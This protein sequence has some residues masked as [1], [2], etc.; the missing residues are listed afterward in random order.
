M[1]KGCRFARTQNFPGGAIH[2]DGTNFRNCLSR[3]KTLTLSKSKNSSVIA[4]YLLAHTQKAAHLTISE[5]ARETGASVATISRFCNRLGYRNYR[6]FNLALAFS[7]VNH[8]SPISDIFQ[9]GDKPGVIVKKV[10]AINRQSLSDTESIFKMSELTSVAKLFK[11][12]GKAFLFGTGGSGLIAK[13]GALRFMALGITTS[14]ISDS[15]EGLLALSSGTKD[16]VAIGISHAG[17]SIG[18]LNM[19]RL[20]RTKGLKTVGIT[21]YPDSPLAKSVDFLLLT[22]FPERRVNAAVSSSR[23]SQMCI[24]DV[25]YFL[26]AY[27]QGKKAEKVALD[28]EVSAEKFLR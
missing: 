18:T 13:I 4:G 11:R 22:S 6:T 9:S 12:G 3:L 15:Y 25:L 8:N 23:I 24:L 10:F 5:L 21:N 20:S 19:I 2:P 1:K 27:Y 26:A 28:V 17:R 7:L 16:D 14:A